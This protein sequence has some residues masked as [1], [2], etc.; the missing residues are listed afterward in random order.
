MRNPWLKQ[1]KTI[2]KKA[3]TIK[4]IQARVF[5]TTGNVKKPIASATEEEFLDR[6]LMHPVQPV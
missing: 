1:N 4:Q 3:K 5:D 2:Q 6:A